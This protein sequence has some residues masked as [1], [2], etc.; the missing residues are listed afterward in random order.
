MV[1][2]LLPSMS[3]D[4]NGSGSHLLQRR[5]MPPY[6]I[7]PYRGRNECWL[8]NVLKAMASLNRPVGDF[9]NQ[10][11]LVFWVGFM[12]RDLG[13]LAVTTGR[14]IDSMDYDSF[15]TASERMREICRVRACVRW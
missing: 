5:R 1:L 12:N 2:P 7:G 14:V 3:P 8:N 15:V 9:E 6:H 4:S 13:F 10:E 11:K